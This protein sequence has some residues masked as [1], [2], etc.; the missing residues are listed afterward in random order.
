MRFC[1]TP[2]PEL[3][4]RR[5]VQ[6]YASLQVLLLPAVGP[7]LLPGHHGPRGDGLKPA[8]GGL[9]VSPACRAVLEQLLVPDPHRR[10]TMEAIKGHPWFLSQLPEGALVMNDY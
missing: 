3:A 4:H 5:P 2:G 9:Q 8:A 10:I 6:V 1:V 7:A